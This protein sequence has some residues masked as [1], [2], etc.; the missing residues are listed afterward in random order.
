[1]S[2]EC[3][4]DPYSHRKTSN[5]EWPWSGSRCSGMLWDALRKY[6]NSR[7]TAWQPQGSTGTLVTVGGSG[8]TWHQAI[9][10]KP[11]EIKMCFPDGGW[12]WWEWK[13]VVGSV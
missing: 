5:F 13:E 3:S 8:T 11:T 2:N 7:G 9:L 4:M 10:L 12:L 6:S 1:M